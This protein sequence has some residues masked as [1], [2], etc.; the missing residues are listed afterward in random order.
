MTEK[1]KPEIIQGGAD[2]ASIVDRTTIADIYRA[3]FYLDNVAVK[4]PLIESPYFTSASNNT[5]FLKPENLQVTGSFKLRGAY[6]RISQLSD[7]E[8]L[9]KADEVI[10]N[11]GTVEELKGQVDRLLEKY[12]EDLRDAADKLSRNFDDGDLKWEVAMDGKTVRMIRITNVKNVVLCY[13]CA[14]KKSST[15]EALY[16]GKVGDNFAPMFSIKIV[17]SVNYLS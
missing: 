14:E 1:K 10:D 11:S 5:V 4:T 8:R 16:R 3:A 7:E 2:V 12:A 6:N 17:R 9:K 15:E 13:E